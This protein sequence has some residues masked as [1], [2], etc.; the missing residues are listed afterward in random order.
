MHVLITTQVFPPEIHPTAVMAA[1][2]AEDLATLGWD[3]TVACGLPH[4]PTGRV[5]RDFSTKLFASE[6]SPFGFTI[7]RVWHPTTPNRRIASRVFVMG[8]QAVSTLLA[9]LSGKKPDVVLSFGGPPIVGPLISAVVAKFFRVPLV[10]VIHDIYPDVLE[11][12]GKL[13]NGR[14]LALLKKVE[15]IQYRWSRS[16][17][18]LGPRTRDV[19]KSRRGVDERQLNIVP[20][21]LDPTE[22]VPQKRSI[23]FRRKHGIHDEQSVVLYAGTVGIVSGAEILADVAHRLPPDRVL[24]VVGGGS[25]W[26]ALLTILKQDSALKGKLVLLPYQPR[27]LVPLVL[28]AAELT[29]VTLSP[30]RGRTSVPSKVQAYMA[31]GRPVLAAVDSDSDTATLIRSGDFGLVVNPGTPQ[32][33]LEGIEESFR[34][35]D[36]LDTWGKRAR[37]VFDEQF[38]RTAQTLKISEILTKTMNGFAS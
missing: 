10:T 13:S 12:S 6:Q 38:S 37:S 1:Q 3:V 5:P 4:H 27:E 25:A 23:D 18:V 2:L 15:E 19:I 9:G 16:L 11:E 36:R 17:I 33:I 7:H 21:W 28:S 35:P 29:L 34:E 24:L 32:A 31:A 20:V 26:D 14:V 22:I 30:G 8:S